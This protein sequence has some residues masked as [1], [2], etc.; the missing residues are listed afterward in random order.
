MTKEK[1]EHDAIKLINGKMYYLFIEEDTRSA[2]DLTAKLLKK[3]GLSTK[4]V[5]ST[6]KRLYYGIYFR[7]K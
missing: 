5:Y 2:A 6:T 1:K 4:I 7:N 3:R